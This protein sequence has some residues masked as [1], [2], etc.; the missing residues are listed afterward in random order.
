MARRSSKTL[1]YSVFYE[2]APE[3]GYVALVPAL[4]GCHTQ[5]ETLEETER[6]VAEAI[7]LYLESLAAHGEPIPQ[8]GRSFQGRVTV[9]A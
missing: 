9:P 8:E 5:G 6:N 4:P 2:Q 3:G 1:S 7:E